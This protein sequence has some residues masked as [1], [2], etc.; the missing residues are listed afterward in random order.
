[1]AFWSDSL[2]PL[3]KYAFKVT[4][5]GGKFHFLAKTVNKPTLETDVNEYRLI[6]Q[7]VK[8]P[9]VPKWNDITIKYVDTKQEK[10]SKKLMKLMM[11]SNMPA[12]SWSADAITKKDIKL[13]IEQLDSKGKVVG[14]W[15][16]KNPFIRSINFGD[17]DYTADDIVEVEVIVSY[18]WAY[19]K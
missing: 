2:E 1:M 14:T 13:K 10:I 12:S 16:F 3:R 11:D 8:F 19:L 17:F 4:I 6:N 18:D 5:D 7:I 15:D 9:T